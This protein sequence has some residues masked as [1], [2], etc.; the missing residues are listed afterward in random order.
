METIKL[1]TG[2][3]SPLVGRMVF[4]NGREMAFETVE[5][6]RNVECPVCGNL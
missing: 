3:G 6:K 2:I 5:V 1:V 4:A